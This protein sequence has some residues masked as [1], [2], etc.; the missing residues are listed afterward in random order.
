MLRQEQKNIWQNLFE[1]KEKANLSEYLKVYQKRIQQESEKLFVSEFLYPI[2]GKYNIK[3]VIPQYPFIDSEGRSRRIDF[4]IIKDGKKLAFEVNGEFYHAEGI[5]P[6][7]MFDDNL[8]RQNEILN[9]GY[10]L[11]RFSYNQL[12]SPAWRKRVFENIRRS[13][14]KKFPELISETIIEPNYLQKEVL[15][16]L[17]LYR[18]KGW[19]KGIVVLPTG[20]G[21]TYLSAFDTLKTNGKILF[22]VHRLD[23][24]NQSKVAFEKIYPKEKLGL[25]TGHVQE[26]LKKSKV[27]FV[28]KDSLKN[29]VHLNIF[30]KD[31]FSYIIVDEVHHGQAPSYKLIL[32]YF[33]P[34]FF[35]LGLTATP[36]R[37]D[38]KDIFEIFDYNKVFEYSLIEAIESGFLVPFNYYG[39]KDNI[40]YSNIRYKGEKYNVRDLD[41][42]LIIEKRNQ[43]IFEEYLEKGKGNKAIGFC[44]SIKHA[45]RM[46]EFFNLQ[47]IPSVA[48]T[49]LTDQRTDLID[50]FK[51]NEVA[52][53]FTVDI[54][55]EG[56]DFPNVQV[57]MFLRPTES[58][59]IFMQ[60]L[61]RGL[62]L[63][64]GKS[65]IVVLDFISNYKKANKIRKYISK[66]LKAVRNP[67]NKRIEKI[68]YKYSP[69]CNVYFDSEVEQIFDAQD[70]Q[71]REITK[72]DLIGAYYDLSESL[73]RKPTQE[74]I[75]Q[76]GE[77]KISKYLSVF[78]SWVKFLR[79]IGEF[80]EA[81]YHF[82]QGLHLGHLLYIIKVVNS[83]RFKKS[84]LNQKFV[85]LRG[86]FDPGRLGTFQRQTKYKLQGLME[87]GLLIDDRTLEKDEKLELKLTPQGLIFYRLLKSVIETL[88]LSFKKKQQ[89][90]PSWDM[91][92]PATDFNLSIRSFLL[93]HKNKKDK[94]RA[95]FLEMH[96]IR[97]MLNYLYRVERKQIIS[98]IDI[99]KGFF[100]S[101][102]VARYCDQNGIEIATEEGAKHR[103]PFLLNVLEAIGI[104]ENR[105][106]EVELKTFLVSPKLLISQHREPDTL[107]KMR[108]EA[109]KKYYLKTVIDLPANELS[110]LKELFG[111]DF[112]TSNYFLNKMEFNNA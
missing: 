28:S 112:L 43:Q 8:S 88:N 30:K 32:D 25:L 47:D 5:I 105:K 27:L 46:A 14:Y 35:M 69:K 109:I 111:K 23:I 51:K 71:E 68:E 6:N 42:H 89:N 70:R 100:N 94:I 59:T 41:R 90:I 97:L 26:N 110:I 79:E 20:T 49:S 83:S 60:Q 11:L 16:N 104:L 9:A 17:D 87:L 86:N 61:G 66:N 19:K 99:Y 85:K 108:F 33:D 56:M 24:L 29:A 57:L 50:K 18:S 73:Q 1:K 21:K 84:H 3:Y 80:T 4:A 2:F 52:V 96:A 64:G 102:E 81:S 78:K 15:K 91:N 22:I 98:K 65:N 95:I 13:V 75:N 55:N 40:N 72:E 54:F 12:Q 37:M 101:Q 31:E 62:R 39:L 48:I 53:A 7:E 107:L 10:Q 106:N 38:R 63:C 77:F 34:S 67:K 45:E 44:C 74:D 76:H 103:C 58:K 82:P 36:D 92:I 93:K